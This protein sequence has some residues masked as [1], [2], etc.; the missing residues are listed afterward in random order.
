MSNLSTRLKYARSRVLGNSTETIPVPFELKCSCGTTVTGIRRTTWQQAVCRSCDQTIFVL[1][2]NV[3]PSS[4]RVPSLVLDG[5]FLQ[6]LKVVTGEFLAS[7]AQSHSESPTAKP[8]KPAKQQEQ[9]QQVQSVAELK[10]YAPPVRVA[11]PTETKESP[12][13]VK[14][15]EAPRR[16]VARKT[17]VPLIRPAPVRRRL[18]TPFRLLVVGAVLAAVGTG[19]WMVHQNQLET[20]RNLWRTSMDDVTTALS[21]GDLSQLSIHLQDAVDAA[22][23]LHRRDA[24]V[25]AAENLLR[26]SHAVNALS[27]IDLLYEIDQLV[28]T[29]PV[30]RTKEVASIDRALDGQWFLFDCRIK[31]RSG[32][33]DDV[34]FDLP[35]VDP[36]IDV[37]FVVQSEW[38]LT[39]Q[40]DVPES[41]LLIAVSVDHVTWNS[42]GTPAL[43]IYFTPASVTLMTSSMHCRLAGLAVDSDAMRQQLER[44]EEFVRG[45]DRVVNSVTS[46]A[47][48]AA[49]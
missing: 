9:E 26:Q 17:V 25:L 45:N 7:P 13:P 23:I 14:P 48:D 19:W 38:L 22:T 6:R 28:L 30:G 18:F 2:V 39:A 40:K 3:Y 44:Q 36:S 35:I 37:R 5:G 41:T 27:R 31:H 8:V 43:T 47:E 46:T 4:K 42:A 24:D 20:A 21:E 1:P 49:I 10:D 16:S 29:E 34:Q 33:T 11:E 32:S 15:A 12:P